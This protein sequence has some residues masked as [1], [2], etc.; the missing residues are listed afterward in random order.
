MILPMVVKPED[1]TG[2]TICG[3]MCPD[4]AITVYK[5]EKADSAASGE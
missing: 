3:Y 1:C 5:L 2:C 4:A